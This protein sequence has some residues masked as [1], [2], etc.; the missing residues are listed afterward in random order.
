MNKFYKT[1]SFT[2]SFII[3]LAWWIVYSEQILKTATEKTSETIQR[4]KKLEQNENNITEIENKEEPEQILELK[5]IKK[6]RPITDY[7]QEYISYAFEIGWFSLVTLIECENA[8][9]NQER[10]AEWK[11]ESYWFCQ[12]NKRWHKEIINNS[13]F[14]TDWKRQINKCYEL[15]K[16]WTKFYWRWRTINWKRCDNYVLNRFEKL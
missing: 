6:E 15:M 16:W 2:L 8:E 7:R 11:E 9:R 12:I 13:L 14:W 3:I 1:V 10:K 5:L 4:V